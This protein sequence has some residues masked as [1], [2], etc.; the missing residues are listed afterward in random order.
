MRD[1]LIIREREQQRLYSEYHES[2]AGN[3]INLIS[4]IL[5]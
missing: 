3:I 2:V 1:F 5:L 4:N